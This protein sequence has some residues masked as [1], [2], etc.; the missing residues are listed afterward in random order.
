VDKALLAAA[1]VLPQLCASSVIGAYLLAHP[2]TAPFFDLAFGGDVALWLGNH[3]VIPAWL[4]VV[5]V[6]LVLRRRRPE[7]RVF[8]AVVMQLYFA[9]NGCLAYF[10]GAHTTLFAGL[11]LLGGATYGFLMFGRRA[12]Y[13]GVATFLAIVALTSVAEQVRLLPYAPIFH[14]APFADHRLATSWFIAPGA[15]DMMALLVILV[16]VDYITE[17]WRAHQ[18]DLARASEQLARANDFISRYIASQ[19]AEQIR[20]GNVEPLERH[21]RR[22]LTLFFS[23]IKGFTEAAER[24]EPEDLS[25]VLN[26]YLSEMTAIAERHGATIDK[27]VGDGMMIFF[28]AP[29]P[30]EE[31]DQAVRAVRM[32]LEMQRRIGDLDPMWRKA[33]LVS[34]LEV[35]MGINTGQ[36]S[37]GNFG[38]KGRVDY[39]A[40]GRQVN[41]AARLQAACTPGRI[42]ISRATWLLVQDAIDAESIGAIEVKGFQR[43]VEVYEVVGEKREAAALS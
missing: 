41:L 17:R 31:H 34:S 37:V 24:L 12:T 15:T 27:F 43:P 1:L 22:R 18:A 11:S 40:I 21:E 19:L 26:L 16:L 13:P 10:F 6:G 20:L 29:L 30:A 25:N 4:G 2:H 32:A 35:R 38:S 9:W 28:G 14:Q 33:G 7:S 36:A 8:V 42:L 39:T 3:V 5:G 23:D